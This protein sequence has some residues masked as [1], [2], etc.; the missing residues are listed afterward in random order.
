MDTEPSGELRLAF[1][2]AVA[3]RSDLLARDHGR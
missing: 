2:K 3:R 1:A